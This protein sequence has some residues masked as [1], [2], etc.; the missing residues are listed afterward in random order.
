MTLDETW[1]A[2]VLGGPSGELHAPSASEQYV[3]L[4]RASDPRVVVD[5]SDTQAMRDAV[6]R[7]VGNR[8][9]TVS[10]PLT[11]GASAL[12]SRRRAAWGV[13]S[14]GYTLREHLSDLLGIEVR[15][16]VSVGP[17]R[18]NRK[19]VVRCYSDSKMIAVAKLGPDVHTADMVRNEGS[20][21]KEFG[22]EPFGGIATPELLV[23]GTF[24]PSELLLMTSLELV[25]DSAIALTDVPMSATEELRDRYRSDISILE[26]PWWL[27]LR[28]RLDGSS[29]QR[30][31]EIFSDLCEDADF[32]SLE[33]SVWHGDWSPWNMGRVKDGRFS[34][35]DWERTAVGVPTGL[36]LVHLHYQYGDGFSGATNGLRKLGVDA[37]R[38]HSM[39]IAYLLELTARH[40]EA[41]A[42]ATDRQ[43]N[44][45]TMIMELHHSGKGTTNP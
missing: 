42:L 34:I 14:E 29:L 10:G 36:D 22:D 13:T 38:Q 41:Q 32:Q 26:S 8:S 5:A 4:P 12:L 40:N 27:T 21:L 3:L 43:S 25:A 6:S 19:P 44:V 11:G 18:P 45:E 30:Y 17:M 37:G 15:L 28:E 16:S 7:F 33:V 1:W 39:N 23:H 31:Q 35:W 20:W 9:R 24:G 2:Q